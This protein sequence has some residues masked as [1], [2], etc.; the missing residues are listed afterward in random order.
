MIQET[1]RIM[2]DFSVVLHKN[3]LEQFGCDFIKNFKI[4]SIKKLKSL[5]ETEIAFYGLRELDAIIEYYGFEKITDLKVFPRIID[6]I[7]TRHEWRL[8][9]LVINTNYPDYDSSDIWFDLYKNYQ[10]KYINILKLAMIGFSFPL[11]TSCCERGFST[12][13][14][15]KCPLRSGLGILLIV[16]VFKFSRRS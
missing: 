3:L 11:S 14:R 10:S 16:I 4:F 13:K 15:I 12:L 8:I 2:A 1:N 7:E 9:K 5:K 6:P